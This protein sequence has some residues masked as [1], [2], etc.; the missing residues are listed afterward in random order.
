[1]SP[2]L[3][4]LLLATRGIYEFW[5]ENKWGAK[6]QSASEKSYKKKNAAEADE[7]VKTFSSEVSSA[8]SDKQSDAQRVRLFLPR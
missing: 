8:I 4:E 2:K 7:F 5:C 1:M 6:T 3:L